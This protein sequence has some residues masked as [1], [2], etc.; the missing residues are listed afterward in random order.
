LPR[1]KKYGETA[2]SWN[3]IKIHPLPITFSPGSGGA[4]VNL[5]GT[6]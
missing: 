4:W 5:P 6:T 1:V 3:I 2:K